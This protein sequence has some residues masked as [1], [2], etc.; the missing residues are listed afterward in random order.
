MEKESRIDSTVYRTDPGSH[1]SPAVAG[2]ARASVEDVYGLPTR[3][4][5]QDPR[6]GTAEVS[7]EP[8]R[9][10][11]AQLR[12]PL[13]TALR[14]EEIMRTSSTLVI[15]VCMVAAPAFAFPIQRR[16]NRPI[17]G[18]DECASTCRSAEHDCVDQA[19]AV[20]SD[21]FAGCEDLAAAARTA[22]EADPTTQDCADARAALRVCAQPCAEGL[23]TA[24]RQCSSEARSCAQD[25]LPAPSD[26]TVA[27][28]TARHDCQLRTRSAVLDCRA[29]CSDE[30]EAARVACSADAQSDECA[31]ARAALHACLQPCGQSLRDDLMQCQVTLRSCVD[32]CATQ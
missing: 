14:G 9:S 16:P 1:G 25:C 7:T 21:C 4:I 17:L 13:Y 27:C 15:A 22:C 29:G 20:S 8:K 2:L 12:R 28:R 24:A 23:R 6:N 5:E 30:R 26:C 3:Q 11:S 31:A 10:A 19:R 18:N 32:A